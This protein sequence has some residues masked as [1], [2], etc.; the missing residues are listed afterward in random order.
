[1]CNSIWACRKVCANSGV[2][3]VSKNDLIHYYSQNGNAKEHEW[4]KKLGADLNWVLSFE[5]VKE[6]ER[7]KHV[8]RL[9]PYKGKFVPQ[10][11]EYFLDIT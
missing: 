7:T 4:K 2:T 8:H 5:G 10:L 3:L 1:M 6:S 11:V 9:H